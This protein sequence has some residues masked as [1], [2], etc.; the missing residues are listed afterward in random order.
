MTRIAALRGPGAPLPVAS[1]YA[2]Q[3]PAAGADD[4]RF[5]GIS[6]ML[7]GKD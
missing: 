3:P 5:T 7:D 4:P 2:Q 1:S 6:T